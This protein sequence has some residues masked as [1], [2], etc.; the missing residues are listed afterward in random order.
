M[1]K[2]HPRARG[3]LITQAIAVILLMIGVVVALYPFYVE[4]LNSLLDA[5]RVAKVEKMNAA[6]VEAQRAKMAKANAALKKAGLHADADPF[7]GMDKKDKVNLQKDQLG[8]VTVPKI[9]LTVPLFKT[10][11]DDTLAVGAAV[12][13]GT[14]M[15]TG[16]PSTH[17]VVAGHRG[18]V[19][20]RLFSD[21]NRV[22]KGNLFVFTVGKHHL[23]Y[24]VF[25]IQ[26]VLPE[27]TDVLQIEPG[28]D[29][30]TLL[31]CTPYMINSHRL[32]L[33]GYRVPYTA[34]IAKEVKAAQ[35]AE[36]WQQLAILIGCA[37][38]L[39]LTLGLLGRYLHGLLLRRHL[40][41]LWF[42]VVDAAGNPVAGVT[43]RLCKPNGKPLYRNR[44]VLRVTTEADG[45]ARIDD[46][47]G[48]MYRL[49]EDQGKWR[50]ACG[51]KKIRQQKMRFYPKKGQTVTLEDGVWRIVK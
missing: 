5:R 14:S 30:A 42:T 32:L 37:L 51:V 24:K 43:Y 21:L 41:D 38:A 18:L 50:V 40:F 12:V 33:T 27:D 10:L 35:S 49:R 9:A 11:T 17:T 22:K 6:N 15:P 47:P 29:L 34:K 4:S 8:T 26:V 46:L 23:A 3:H 25:R 1:A 2:K 28:R 48:R 39:L 16:G 20:R 19:D 36:T 45:T 7:S 44:Q 31:T 13:P